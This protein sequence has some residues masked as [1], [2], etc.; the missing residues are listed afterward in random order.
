MYSPENTPDRGLMSGRPKLEFGKGSM[1]LLIAV[2]LILVLGKIFIAHMEQKSLYYPS[3]TMAETPD[4]LHIDYENIEIT[5]PD[6]TKL[7]AWFVRH[8][9]AKTT[10]L[11]CH[12]NAGNISHRL[13]R[14]KFFHNL[15]ANVLLW[16][17]RGYGKST[18]RPSEKGLYQDVLAVCDY[19]ITAKNIPVE[20]IIAYGKSLGCAVVTELSRHREIG[21]L[22]LESPFISV[23]QIAQEM[24]P[25]LPM[26]YIIRQK[27]DN[28]GKLAVSA[29]PKLILHGRYDE[30]ID[31]HHAEM[32]HQQAAGP[33]TFL[34]FDG[35]HNDIIYVTSQEYKKVF[36]KIMKNCQTAVAKT[37][38]KN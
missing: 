4:A 18:G 3:R 17:Y 30:I 24:I 16:D 19:L 32:L 28:V 38:K 21:Y 13:F 26:K 10:V 25:W 8:P 12:G 37:K 34:S 31:Y 23:T 11:F 35:G 22:V 27:Y 29:V 33:K 6:G 20:S 9:Q 15:Q 7:H 14:I 36:Q 2:V 5:T 1:K